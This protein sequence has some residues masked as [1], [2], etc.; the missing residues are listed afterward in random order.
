MSLIEAAIV[1]L[2]KYKKL[3]SPNLVR[4][5][6]KVGC[7]LRWVG[8]AKR[9]LLKERNLEFTKNSLMNKIYSDYKFIY[10]MLTI[11]LANPS[12]MPTSK[13]NYL[14]VKADKH[15]KTLEGDLLKL[16]DCGQED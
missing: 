12:Y 16:K 4:V 10:E 2:K 14:L 11:L 5:A 13:E 3:S 7:S 9:R 8:E 1:E 15:F 6:N